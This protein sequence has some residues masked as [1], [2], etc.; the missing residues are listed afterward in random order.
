LNA[1]KSHLA[2]FS[3]TTS[4]NGRRARLIG[5]VILAGILLTGCRAKA[6]RDVYQ[7]KMA[8][9]IRNL[10]DQ[11]YAADY[12]NQILV[13]ELARARSQ[14]VVPEARRSR[15]VADPQPLPVRP[16]RPES[17]AAPSGLQPPLIP[18]PAL[19]A[20]PLPE[21]SPPDL[22]PPPIERPRPRNDQNLVP[23]TVPIPPGRSTL[24]FPDV[25]LGTPVPPS[26]PEA[27]PE[28]PPGQI[29]IPES[30]KKSLRSE[31]SIPVAV[32][33][34]QSMSGGYRFDDAAKQTGMHL[35][36][37]AIDEA[38]ERVAL[39]QFN[40]AGELTVVLLDPTREPADARL[41]LWEYSAQEVRDMI[42]PG[43]GSAIHVYIPWR[44]KIPGGKQVM[45]HVKLFADET[46]MQAQ[47]ELSTAETEVAQW[48]PRGE[49]MKR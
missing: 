17:P 5:L 44:D 43:V 39:E 27:A 15:P 1:R 30:A 37:E 32:R 2:P 21:P 3:T 16:P 20:R 14:I 41:G 6:Y 25:D 24:E 7:Q 48:N 28:L 23:P 29:K 10:E 12:Q 35:S 42:R 36:I 49:A 40:L 4:V 45:A 33:I 22:A 13:D 11:L 26:G 47:A 8:G 34:N 46:Q 9:E 38:G 18:T 31:P 19:P